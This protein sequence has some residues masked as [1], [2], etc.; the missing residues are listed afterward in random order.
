[1]FKEELTLILHKMFLKKEEEETLPNSFY[2]GI[3]AQ[4]PK[5]DIERK[6]TNKKN[7]QINK[8]LMKTKILNKILTNQT[9]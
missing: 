7:L 9:Q 4:I 6:K 8:N 2:E 1:M 3:I 5:P